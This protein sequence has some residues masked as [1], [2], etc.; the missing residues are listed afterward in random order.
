L[1]FDLSKLKGSKT[2]EAYEGKLAKVA[3]SLSIQYD[4]MSFESGKEVYIKD[5]DQNE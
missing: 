4:Y 1:V 5:P 3:K 2:E